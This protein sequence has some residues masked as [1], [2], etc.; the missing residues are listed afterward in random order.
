M[1]ALAL[2]GVVVYASFIFAPKGTTSRATYMMGDALMAVVLI[3]QIMNDTSCPMAMASLLW[4]VFNYLTGL[5]QNDPKWF[6]YDGFAAA[7]VLSKIRA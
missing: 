1:K 7:S 2:I 5:P 3:N 4:L 6:A